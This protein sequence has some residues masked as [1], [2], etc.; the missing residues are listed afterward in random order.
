M[1]KG[2]VVDPPAPDGPR[3]V[4][5]VAAQRIRRAHRRMLGEGAAID[6][7]SPAEALHELRIS[8]KEL[9][10]LL[11]LYAGLYDPETLGGVVRELK[12]LQD[13]L[14]EFQDCEVHAQRLH[15]FAEELRASTDV[16]TSVLMA[17]AL[18]AR[19]FGD[20]QARARAAFSGRFRAFARPGNVRALQ[21]MV[22]HR[23]GPS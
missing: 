4:G 2:P 18:V 11:E 17:V 19:V 14:G 23:E 22:G 21:R 12:Q 16:P 15:G 9:R 3:P 20:R 5:E 1:R 6:E 8:G 13:N 7:R 10:Y